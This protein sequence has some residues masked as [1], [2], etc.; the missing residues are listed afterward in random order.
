MKRKGTSVALC[1][2]AQPRRRFK[3]KKNFNK[4]WP[5]Y[6]MLMVPIVYLIIFHWIPMGGL[7]IMFKDYKMR[8]GIADSPWL[9]PWYDNFAWAFESPVFRQAVWNTISISLKR[10]LI[11][12]PCPIILAILLHELPFPRLKKITQT[13]SYLPNFLS[14][15]ILGG[16]L[17]NVLSLDGIVNRFI[18][19][20][21]MEPVIYAPDTQGELTPFSLVPMDGGFCLDKR[22]PVKRLGEGIPSFRL[23]VSGEEK[24][25][26]F[27][28]ICP[29]EPFGYI[30]RL[31]E[32]YLVQKNGQA[33][34]MIG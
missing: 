30:A 12:F 34:I 31:K 15:V 1:G 19:L 5:F 10:L 33:G 23:L 22:I 20:L 24:K 2:S 26:H 4:Y 8:L 29:E 6:L 27:V 28:P 32:S 16:I 25:M 21:G 18:Q 11:G 9:D 13:T 14:W 17:T 7:V 3:F